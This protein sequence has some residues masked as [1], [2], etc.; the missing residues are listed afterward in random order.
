MTA[1]RLSALKSL[2]QNLPPTSTLVVVQSEQKTPAQPVHL[3]RASVVG[4]E[5]GQGEGSQQERADPRA[6]REDSHSISPNLLPHPMQAGA[7]PSDKNNSVPG[8]FHNHTLP[9]ESPE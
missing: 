1:H 8:G 6:R 3:L 9:S 4:G 7:T 5:Q 2:A